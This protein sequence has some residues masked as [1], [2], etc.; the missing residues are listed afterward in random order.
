VMK[1]E[2]ARGMRIV[3][4][5]ITLVYRY[6]AVDQ[7]LRSF[8]VEL[9][10]GEPAGSIQDHDSADVSPSYLRL[11]SRCC[12]AAERL[13]PLA[14]AHVPDSSHHARGDS[15][16]NLIGLAAAFEFDLGSF[17]KA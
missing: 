15:V 2:D 13:R 16:R 8:A 5:P 4:G 1:V 12:C 17:R 10:S 14:A 3:V 7:A 9:G 11:Q 6:S